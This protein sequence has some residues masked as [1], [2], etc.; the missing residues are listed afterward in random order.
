MTSLLL[1]FTLALFL[2]YILTPLVIRGA[3]KTGL[4]DV[5]TDERRAHTVPIPRLGGVAVWVSISVTWLGVAIADGTPW[6]PFS[7]NYGNLIA[8]LGVGAALIFVAGLFDDVRGLAPRVK[9]IIQIV[10]A[11]SIVSYGFTPT[12][13]AI[14]PNGTV[15]HAGEAIGAAVFVLWIVGVSNAFNLIDGLDGLASSFALIAAAVVMFSAL[16]IHAGVSPSSQR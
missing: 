5:P 15:W 2:A 13:I 6:N 1:P 10:S 12:A 14:T 16:A 4:L 7:A 8:G 3:H 9:L 11:L